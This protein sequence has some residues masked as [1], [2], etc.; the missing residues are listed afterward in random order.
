MSTSGDAAVSETSTGGMEALYPFLYSTEERD[1]SSVLDEVASS[2]ARKAAE[3]VELRRTVVEKETTRLAECAA[4]MATLFASGGR[5]F[6]FGNGGSS[7]D[8]QDVVT[9]FLRPSHGRPLPALSLT[10]DVAV[11][12]ALS[13]D[14]AFEVIYARQL[15]ALGRQG[16]IAVG[17]STS[18][19]SANVLAGFEE[20]RRRG[21]L[22]VGLAGYDGG[23]MA[24]LDAIDHLFVV[25]SPSVHRIQETQTTLYHLLWELTQR[26][27]PMVD[28]ER[29][30]R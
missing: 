26:A 16:D 18:G 8:S 25:P 14:V 20:A 17:L 19:G 13:N 7:T 15:G 6:A 29:T 11:I 1:V 24:E 28:G 9:T 21:M 22:T 27:L 23:R 4:A 12:T 10:S 3:I 5:L 30:E 2:T